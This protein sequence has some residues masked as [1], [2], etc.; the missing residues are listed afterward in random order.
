[1]STP[2]TIRIDRHFFTRLKVTANPDFEPNKVERP[3]RNAAVASSMSVQDIPGEPAILC[4]QTVKLE[5]PDK[6]SIPYE[7]DIECVGFF[8]CD[9]GTMDGAGRQLAARMAHQVLYSAVRE[10]VITM[11]AR[12][13]WGPFSI[14]LAFLKTSATLLAPALDAKPKRVTR[15]RKKVPA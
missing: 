9:T 11:T 8:V 12:M 7:L 4:T 2:Q 3:I 15:S 13:A 6:H 10:M 5:L 1:M 14:G